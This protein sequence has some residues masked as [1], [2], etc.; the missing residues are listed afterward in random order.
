[1]LAKNSLPRLFKGEWLG[2]TFGLSFDPCEDSCKL[3]PPR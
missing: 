3:Y 1:L 2:D